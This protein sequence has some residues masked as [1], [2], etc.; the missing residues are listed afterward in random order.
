[1]F[2]KHRKSKKKETQNEVQ[3]VVQN[4]ESPIIIP[5]TESIQD[6]LSKKILL[7]DIQVGKIYYIIC[8]DKNY[9]FEYTPK[10]VKGYATKKSTLLENQGYGC[11]VTDNIPL[12]TE[13][14][15]CDLVKSKGVISRGYEHTITIDDHELAASIDENNGFE[16]LYAFEN[17]NDLNQAYEVIF[18]NYKTAK[19]DQMQNAFKRRVDQELGSMEADKERYY[20]KVGGLDND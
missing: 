6:V 19:L 11:Q 18:E 20:K 12:Y 13:V 10:I 15:F 3:T 2:K 8:F 5:T 1:M 17:F 4:E 7:K 16:F 9:P 14:E